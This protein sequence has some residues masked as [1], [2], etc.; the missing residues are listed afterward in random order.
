M[1]EATDENDLEI[2]MVFYVGEHIL[3]TMKT[4]RVL[5]LVNYVG[6]EMQERMAAE[7]VAP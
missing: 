3:T 2:A 5:A 6:R 1:F 4:R 7:I